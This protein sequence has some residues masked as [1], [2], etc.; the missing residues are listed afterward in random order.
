MNADNSSG[1][2][3]HP[4][5][6][7]LQGKLLQISFLLCWLAFSA[8]LPATVRADSAETFWKQLSAC[9]QDSDCKS[10]A[11]AWPACNHICGS[12]KND[13][14]DTTTHVCAAMNTTTPISV[15]CAWNAPCREPKRIWCESGRCKSEA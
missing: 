13:R 2:P 10:A 8:G 7:A 1:Q 15:D 14:C 5:L 12:N 3:Q 4:T 9:S 6:R 11:V